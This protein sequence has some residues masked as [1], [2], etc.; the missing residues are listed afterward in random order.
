MAI[1]DNGLHNAVHVS[2]RSNFIVAGDGAWQAPPLV[3]TD[4]IPVEYHDYDSDE[5]ELAACSRRTASPSW[6]DGQG[7][8]ETIAPDDRIMRR[9]RSL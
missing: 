5:A 8:A 3:P 9:G 2:R 6:V 1:R 7:S 4:L